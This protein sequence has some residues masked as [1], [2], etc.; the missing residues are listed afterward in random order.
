MAPRLWLLR[1]AEPVPLGSL[2]GQSISPKELGSFIGGT[3]SISKGAYHKTVIFIII[4]FIVSAL[5]IYCKCVR[6]E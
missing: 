4:D 2:G 1:V 3:Q 6:A 5:I